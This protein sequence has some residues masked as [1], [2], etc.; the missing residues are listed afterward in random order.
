MSDISIEAMQRYSY[1]TTA[2]ENYLKDIEIV[3]NDIMYI[4]SPAL[5]GKAIE[6]FNENLKSAKL[7]LE[8]LRSEFSKHA[9]AAPKAAEA[10]DYKSSADEDAFKRYDELCSK[11]FPKTPEEIKR[12]NEMYAKQ[13]PKTLEMIKNNKVVNLHPQT[14]GYAVPETQKFTDDEIDAVQLREDEKIS[15]NELHS[16]LSAIDKLNGAIDKLN[17]KESESST[18]NDADNPANTLEALNSYVGEMSKIA[19]TDLSSN[20]EQSSESKKTKQKRSKKDK[21]SK[22][23]KKQKSTSKAPKSKEEK[24]EQKEKSK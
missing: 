18:A 11:K 12:Y 9:D 4:K 2:V 13:F 17:G 8:Y 16:Y 24:T 7:K 22:K 1:C 20:L 3:V 10:A 21:S 19:E 6:L 23:D 5:R 14:P 15:D